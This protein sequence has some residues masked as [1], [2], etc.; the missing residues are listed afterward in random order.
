MKKILSVA[1]SRSAVV[2]EQLLNAVDAT[3][4]T[5]LHF[6]A[7]GAIWHQDV[8]KGL[9]SLNYNRRTSFEGW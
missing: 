3:G 8:S 9:S 1:K 6:A 4:N 5:P 2:L 7:G